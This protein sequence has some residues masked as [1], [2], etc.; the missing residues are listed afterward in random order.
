MSHHHHHDHTSTNLLLV[1]LL[2]IT[3]TVAEII[4]G[5]ISNSLALISDAMHNLSDATAILIAWIA[6]KV[7]RRSPDDRKTFGYKRIEIIAALFNAT[8]LIVITVYLFFEAWKRFSEPSEIKGVVM[9]VVAS[10]GL[11]ANGISVLILRENSGHN[12]NVK[13]AYLHLLG[14]TLSS[15]AVILGAVAI[16]FLKIYWIDPVLTIV[17]GLY[18]LYE[19]WAIVKEALHIL[20]QGAPEGVKT[21]TIQSEIESIGGISRAHH[22]HVWK[23]TDNI[24]HLECH[25]ELA[26]NVSVSETS[27]ILQQV[28]MR[29][30]DKFNIGHVTVQFEYGPCQ[31]EDCT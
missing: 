21:D 3:I 28:K 8:V 19:T 25:A 20:M 26:N 13:A 10:V 6:G 24:I 17:I 15:V 27:I 2:N 11:I 29:L 18:I 14:D 31:G 22:I 12:L 5:L 7:A 30:S 1:T 16:I 4:G 9:L 23:L